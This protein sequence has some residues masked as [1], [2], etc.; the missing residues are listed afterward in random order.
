[1]P[2]IFDR[3]TIRRDWKGK[4]EGSLSISGAFGEA[5]LNLTEELCAKILNVCA[6]NIVEA[7]GITANE[8]RREALQ[9]G[10]RTIDQLAKSK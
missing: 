8:F 2:I 1:M 3:V 6:D 9:L 7:A 10:T 4:L 5:S